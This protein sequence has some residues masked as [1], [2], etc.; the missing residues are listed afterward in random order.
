MYAKH[1]KRLLGQLMM[2]CKA[3]FN[4]EL[5]KNA[6]GIF[7]QCFWELIQVSDLHVMLS[8]SMWIYVAIFCTISFLAEMHM[9]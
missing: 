8:F 5:L 2:N 3:K 9:K 1:Y 4:L 7:K 6:F